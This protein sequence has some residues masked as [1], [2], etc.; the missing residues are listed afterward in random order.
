MQPR[1]DSFV[2]HQLTQNN[3]NQFAFV[4]G[5]NKGTWQTMFA[6]EQGKKSTAN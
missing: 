3:W 2:R 6:N 4:T 5:I 1:E